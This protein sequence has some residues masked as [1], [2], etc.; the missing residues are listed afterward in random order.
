MSA[1]AMEQL[2]GHV[3]LTATRE[4]ETVKEMFPARSYRPII[5]ECVI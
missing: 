4:Q 2:C 5:R 1:V 3:D